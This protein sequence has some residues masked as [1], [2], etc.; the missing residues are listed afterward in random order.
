MLPWFL[1][2][3]QVVR[4]TRGL[5]YHPDMYNHAMDQLERQG[6]GEDKVK[7]RVIGGGRIEFYPDEGTCFVYGYSKSFGRAPGCNAKSA[8]LVEKAYPDLKVTWSDDGY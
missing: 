6:L 7:G 1:S 3:I 8:E 5:P 2:S 4:N